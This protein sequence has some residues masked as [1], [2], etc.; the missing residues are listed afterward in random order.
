MERQFHTVF[1]NMASLLMVS[2]ISCQSF[3]LKIADM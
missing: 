2:T 3:S 1:V